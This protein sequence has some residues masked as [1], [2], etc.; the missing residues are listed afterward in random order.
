MDNHDGQKVADHLNLDRTIAANNMC[1][2]RLSFG[3]LNYGIVVINQDT[4]FD[5]LE[6]LWCDATLLSAEE[7]NKS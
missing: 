7:S 6:T 5:G 4:A 1:A 3:F 2:E